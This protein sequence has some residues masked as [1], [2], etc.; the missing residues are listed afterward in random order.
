MLGTNTCET[1]FFGHNDAVPIRVFRFRFVFFPLD[2]MFWIIGTRRS[3]S[4]V[5]RNLA[6]S[7]LIHTT[8]SWENDFFC[9]ISFLPFDIWN[10]LFSNVVSVSQYRTD[11][12]VLFHRKMHFYGIVPKFNRRRARRTAV[13]VHV[14]SSTTYWRW[15]EPETVNR[16]IKTRK[17]AFRSFE[18][19]NGW[20]KLYLLDAINHASIGNARNRSKNKVGGDGGVCV[21]ISLPLAMTV[22][23]IFT[24]RLFVPVTEIGPEL[25]CLQLVRLLLAAH[26][27][28][29]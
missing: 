10:R 7:C 1:M 15:I 28:L 25:L 16:Q 4:A 6:H 11:L 22:R 29:H 12:L 20:H 13:V 8:H 3:S 19:L 9:S 18:R 23:T 14:T 27:I 2:G 17:W 5:S 26:K 21:S 24:L